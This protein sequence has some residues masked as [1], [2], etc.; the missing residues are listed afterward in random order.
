MTPGTGSGGQVA[1]T[2]KTSTRLFWSRRISQIA[3]TRRLVD[4][5]V[6]QSLTPCFWKPKP[7]KMV[8]Q[9]TGER[10]GGRDSRMPC[11][12]ES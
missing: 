2:L 5:D 4:C 12:P 1:G 10:I 9:T 8:V 11:R 3:L 7:V 6:F